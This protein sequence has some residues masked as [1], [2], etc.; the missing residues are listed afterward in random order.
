MALS[1]EQLKSLAIEMAATMPD[2]PPRRIEIVAGAMVSSESMGIARSYESATPL[3]KRALEA[4][5]ASW[6]QAR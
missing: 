3:Q 6:E 4:V 1:R 5:V 2:P